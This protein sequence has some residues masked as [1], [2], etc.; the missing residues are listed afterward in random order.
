MKNIINQSECK[1]QSRVISHHQISIETTID[2][3][4][5][6]QKREDSKK[7]YSKNVVDVKY[8]QK[9]II[10]VALFLLLNEKAS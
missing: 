6:F 4:V 2:N 5:E 9:R 8:N 1:I 3:D 7:F 10:D